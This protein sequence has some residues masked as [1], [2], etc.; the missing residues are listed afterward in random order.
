[1]LAA[2]T[3]LGPYE[4]LSAL[5]AGGMGEVYKA[6]DTRLNRTVAIK[7]LPNTD[8]DAI[9]RFDREA[10]AIAALT[11]PHICTLYDVGSAPNSGASDAMPFLVM[12]HLEGETLAS[13]LQK[14]AL[15]VDQTVAIALEIAD[16]LDKAHRAGIVHRDLKPANVMLTKAGVKLLDFGLAK[17]RAQPAVAMGGRGASAMATQPAALTGLGTIL[18][19]L[20]YMSPEQVEGKE[21]DHRADIWALGCLLHEMTTGR[22]PF[23]GANPATV[24]AA[25]LTTDAVA[26]RDVAS[27]PPALKRIV[28]TCLAKDPDDRWQDARDLLR[29][30]RWNSEPDG[31]KVAAASAAGTPSASR[32]PWVAA[33]VALSLLVIGLAARQFTR[34]VPIAPTVRFTVSPPPHTTFYD[35]ADPVRISPDGQRIAFVVR[36]AQNLAQIWIQ[37]LDGEPQLLAGTEGGMYPFWSPDSQSIAFFTADALKRLSVTNQAVQTIC[38]TPPGVSGAWSRNGVIVFASGLGS[39]SLLKV[40][41]GG[42]TPVRLTTLDPSRQET[43]HVWP[44]FLPD[45]DRFLYLVRTARPENSGLY[46]S[47]VTAPAPKLLMA[48]DSNAYVADGRLFFVRQG[49]LWAQPFDARRAQLSDEP[50]RVVDR[51]WTFSGDGGAAF[52]AS[53][54]ASLVYRPAA[55]LPSE[56]TWLDRNGKRL[57]SIGEPAEYTHVALSPDDG[58]VA[59]ERIDPKTSNGVIWLHDVAR[60]LTARFSLDGSWSWTPVWSP[61][62]TR[63]AF[64]ST[65]QAASGVGVYEKSA[66]G[67]TG[68]QLLFNSSIVL[69]PTDWS[70]DGRWLVG[71][72]MGGTTSE[73]WSVPLAG[74]RKPVVIQKTLFNENEARLSPDGHWLAYAS[75]EAGRTDVYVRSFP[76]GDTKRLVSQN[77]GRQPAWRRDGRELFYRTDEGDV[78]AVDVKPAAAFEAG[79][80]RVLFRARIQKSFFGHYDY[81]VTSD[82]QRFLVNLLS[83]DAPAAPAATMILNWRSKGR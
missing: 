16:A 24:I 56:L 41:E 18:G 17:L 76:G 39:G 22:K 23:D 38:A 68:E 35:F 66:S 20:H 53:D 69:Q 60:T 30:L 15:S 54:G 9:A 58:R 21:A 25:I 77:G 83:A 2:G 75:N 52:S 42:G 59:I 19:T 31:A 26:T 10:R 73:L 14:G 57:G 13:R 62:G 12:E 55:G 80:P 11:H 7:I 27:L 65:S 79:A 47:S 82:G 46:L 40:P 1:M 44:Q 81:A 28:V 4:I 72:V 78:I 48:V 36:N 5:G 29:E 37:S 32:V 61:D 8:P 63:V 34:T 70:R 45:G 64:G 67:A 49:T 71:S 51:V 43:M 50:V 74:D 3:K 33:V 6:S